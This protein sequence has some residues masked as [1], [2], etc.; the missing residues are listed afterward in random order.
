MAACDCQR[1]VARYTVRS[2]SHTLSDEI[3]ILRPGP[4]EP[5]PVLLMNTIWA[6]RSGVHDALTQPADL[7]AWLA[8][9]SEQLPGDLSRGVAEVSD[10]D[11]R[12]FRD[13]RS[14]LRR[15]AAD[16][17]GDS[18]DHVL[19]MLDDRGPEWA[20][21]VINAASAAAPPVPRLTWPDRVAHMTAPT[22]R[23]TPMAIMSAIAAQAVSL[24][25]D[26][27]SKALQ[28]CNAPGCV[29]YFVRD[30]PRRE[31]CSEACGNRARAR[32]HYDRHRS[33]AEADGNRT[34]QRQ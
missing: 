5:L 14:A 25:G 11:V 21:D 33:V 24:F 27:D 30:H 31:W 32:R 3:A 16:A 6:D 26:S 13:L 17:S 8:A 19:E 28:A 20:V 4:N 22:G 2:V 1:V 15:L 29:L 7:R 12:R 34:H 18:R 10:R 9:V 23:G